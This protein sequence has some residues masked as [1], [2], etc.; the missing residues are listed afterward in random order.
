[1]LLLTLLTVGSYCYAQT[2]AAP[3]LAP[4]L[5]ELTKL[6]VEN[7]K[8]KNQLVQCQVDLLDRESK[9]ASKELTNQQSSLEQQM[10]LELKC[11]TTDKFN[12]STLKCES[13]AK[14]PIK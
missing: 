4:E 7:F 9:L 6:K 2:P 8:L 13:D 10:R 1:M 14:K 11:N 12:W 3:V 5:S